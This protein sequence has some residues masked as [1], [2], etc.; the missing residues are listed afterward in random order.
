[1]SYWTFTDIFEESGPRWEAF[2]GGFGL[3][4]YQDIKKPSYYAY[5]FLNQ[6]GATELK[7]SDPSSWICTGKD[8]GVQALIWDF[9]NTFPGS[10]MINQVFYKRDLPAQPKGKATLNLTNLRRGNYTLKIYKAGYRV[11]DAYDTYRDLGTPAQLTKAQ[12]AEI[13][14]KNSGAPLEVRT[15][16][17][18]RDGKFT[19]QFDLRENDAVLITLKPQK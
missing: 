17:I 15:M 6:L 13:K 5:Q 1:M 7:N 18:G 10:N 14:S 8:G 2:H 12:V 16:K 9:T 3:M 19:Q 11:N 4:N